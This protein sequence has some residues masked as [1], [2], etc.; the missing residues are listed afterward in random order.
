MKKVAQGSGALALGVTVARDRDSLTKPVRSPS[1]APDEAHN[2]ERGK[3]KERLLWAAGIRGSH[4][5]LEVAGSS[6]RLDVHR[7]DGCV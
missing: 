6:C 5:R 1:I 2:L 4:D 7:A 3:R